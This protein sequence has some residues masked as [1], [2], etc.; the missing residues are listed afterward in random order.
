MEYAG[1]SFDSEP[2]TQPELSLIEDAEEFDPGRLGALTAE[3]IIAFDLYSQG[4][5]INEIARLRGA[6]KKDIDEVVRSVPGILQTDR[7][8]ATLTLLKEGV[9]SLTADEVH[10]APEA[11]L[12]LAPIFKETLGAFVIA[13]TYAEAAALLNSSEEETRLL[14]EDAAVDMRAGYSMAR[15]ARLAYA[16]KLDEYYREKQRFIEALVTA[17]EPEIEPA[18]LED[19]E[20]FAD[21]EAE[22]EEAPAIEQ[23]EDTAEER[24]VLSDEARA[25]IKQYL[26]WMYPGEEN[27][28][29]VLAGLND[30]QLAVLSK[31]ALAAVMNYIGSLPLKK[32][33][34]VQ[35]AGEYA[36]RWLIGMNVAAIANALDRNE[37][38]VHLSLKPFAEK[39]GKAAPLE[40]FL[41]ES[42]LTYTPE[43]VQSD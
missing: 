24:G 20:S 11:T 27:L 26:D 37:G 34:Q 6:T 5:E 32:R 36:D 18:P 42:Q 8:V 1:D 30:D 25:N 9:L 21:T 2:E 4:Y 39:V 35:M 28:S 31:N 16:A 38:R 17:P 40:N 15:I 41:A 14:I 10:A 43:S 29:D 3:Q 23:S 33:R 19:H 13:G 7:A 12:S 22:S